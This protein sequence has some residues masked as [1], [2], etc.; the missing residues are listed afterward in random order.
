[1]DNEL[2]YPYT[3]EIKMNELLID[4]VTMDESQNHYAECKKAGTKELH[5]R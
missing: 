2:V 1:M 4:T 5:N 3:M